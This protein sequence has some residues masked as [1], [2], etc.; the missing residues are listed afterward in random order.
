MFDQVVVGH[1][2]ADVE[3]GNYKA[4][5]MLPM[6]SIR[7]DTQV[8]ELFHSMSD[9]DETGKNQKLRMADERPCA[10][11]HYPAA[12]YIVND[13]RSYSTNPFSSVS[14]LIQ[15]HQHVYTHVQK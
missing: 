2:I 6:L 14:S 8:F 7:V 15:K 10:T 12:S 1:R 4:L 11:D 3:Y 13:I 9:D 5:S